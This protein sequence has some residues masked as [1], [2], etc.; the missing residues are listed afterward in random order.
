MAQWRPSKKFWGA[1]EGLYGDKSIDPI[2]DNGAE[3]KTPPRASLG[4]L[5]EEPTQIRFVHWCA[6]IL[7]ELGYRLHHSPNGGLRSMREG[8]KFKKMGTSRGFPDLEFPVPLNGYH[9]LY[10]EM[11]SPNGTLTPEQKYWGAYLLKMGYQWKIARGEYEAKTVFCEYFGL[12]LDDT[13][14]YQKKYNP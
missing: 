9:G 13:Q 8:A 6:P 3:K 1:Y 10:I 14:N 4:R 2:P 7:A 5:K 12:E 11:K